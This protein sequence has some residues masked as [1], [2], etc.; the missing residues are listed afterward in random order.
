MLNLYLFRWVKTVTNVHLLLL[1]FQAKSISSSWFQQ[2]QSEP[3]LPTY[4]CVSVI[5]R[6]GVLSTLVHWHMFLGTGRQGMS[7]C[8]GNEVHGGNLKMLIFS[9]ERWGVGETTVFGNS[10]EQ[11]RHT[12]W[13]LRT[14]LG[15]CHHV[16]RLVLV[17]TV[18][19]VV[20]KG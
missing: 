15:T 5:Q 4:A 11:P 13:R 7:R 17:V 18:C 12:G 2:K 19:M 20:R 1:R 3:I 8:C 10:V 9:V 16:S 6:F 14:R